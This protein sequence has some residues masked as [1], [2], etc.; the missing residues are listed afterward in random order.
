MT[1]KRRSPNKGTPPR[2]G[3]DAQGPQAQAVQSP[4]RGDPPAATGATVSKP[5]VLPVDPVVEVTTVS[6]T[7]NTTQVQQDVGSTSSV[8]QVG[9]AA[10]AATVPSV[11]PSMDVSTPETSNTSSSRAASKATVTGGNKPNADTSSGNSPPS[12]DA[13][14]RPQGSAAAP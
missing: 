3:G 4:Q 5:V 9:N 13:P 12:A 6:P 10:P 7:D 2:P 1:G 8:Q 14:V 11:T